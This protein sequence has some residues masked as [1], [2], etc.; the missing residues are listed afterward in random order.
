M[1]L[2]DVNTYIEWI[3]HKVLLYSTVRCIQYPII[4]HNEKEM[5]ENIYAYICITLLYNIINQL[6]SIK[7][8]VFKKDS[9]L[10]TSEQQFTFLMLNGL[11]FMLV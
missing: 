9:L 11:E 1:G 2:A 7:Y 8:I 4:N 5:K 3:S 6:T 10:L